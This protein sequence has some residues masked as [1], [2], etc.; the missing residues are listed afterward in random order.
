MRAPLLISL[1]ALGAVGCGGAAGPG[2]GS[3]NAAGVVS[4]QQAPEPFERN[5]ARYKRGGSRPA[6]TQAFGFRVEDLPRIAAGPNEL[7]KDKD[8]EKDKKAKEPPLPKRKYADASIAY[9]NPASPRAYARISVKDLVVGNIRIGYYDGFV[10]A[11]GVMRECGPGLPQYQKAEQPAEWRGVK[12]DGSKLR[13]LLGHGTFD[14][15]A[16]ELYETSVRSVELMAL[17][18]TPFHAARVDCEACG[19]GGT[20]IYVFAPPLG[21]TFTEGSVTSAAWSKA[22]L[23]VIDSARGLA[24][25]FRGR[26]VPA[27]AQEWGTITGSALKLGTPEQLVGIDVVQGVG[28]ALPEAIAFMGPARLQQ[29]RGVLDGFGGEGF[30][31]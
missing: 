1:V 22:Q 16:C 3:G 14:P 29:S 17:P 24:S 2:A 30:E 19:P 26:L 9:D 23:M 31:E 5:F 21:Q 8:K 10:H 20:R 7:K 6:N 18:G 13:L 28:D 12:K 15:V 27:T 11:G 25:A 4:V